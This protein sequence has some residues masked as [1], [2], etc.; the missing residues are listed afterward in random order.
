MA[1]IDAMSVAD[2]AV[3]LEAGGADP[4]LAAE[5]ARTWDPRMSAAILGLYR[6]AIDPGSVWPQLDGSVGVPTLVLW[7]GA[8]TYAP[9]EFGVRVAERT[10]ADLVVFDGCPHWWPWSRADEVADRLTAL[11]SGA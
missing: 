6:S 8:D 5:Q 2:R 3:I 4:D 11:W 1:G 9:P 10:G 7:G